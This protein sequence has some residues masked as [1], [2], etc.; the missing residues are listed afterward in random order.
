MQKMK[1][2]HLSSGRRNFEKLT[3]L[4]DIKSNNEQT[5]EQN[6]IE[7]KKPESSLS[8]APQVNEFEVEKQPAKK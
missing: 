8:A 4:P 6:Q 7:N 5:K 1:M 2:L 3:P